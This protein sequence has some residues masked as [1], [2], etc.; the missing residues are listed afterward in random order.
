ME[1][2]KVSINLFEILIFQDN[3]WN[4]ELHMGKERKQRFWTY[5]CFFRSLQEPQVQYT[6]STIFP[7]EEKKHQS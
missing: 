7:E 1:Q 6:V 2:F 4:E 3:A 5:L